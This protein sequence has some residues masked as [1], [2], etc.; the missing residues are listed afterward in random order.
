MLKRKSKKPTSDDL[1]SE[2]SLSREAALRDPLGLHHQWYLDLRLREEIARTEITKSDGALVAWQLS[3]LPGEAIDNDQF[4]RSAK[5]IAKAMRSYDIIARTDERRF[6]AIIF[7]ANYE[8][9]SAVAHRVCLELQLV[10]SQA[11]RWKA[12]VA[13]FRRDGRNGE[14]LIERVLSRIDKA[15]KATAA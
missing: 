1:P 13:S 4:A 10:V 7:D 5:I 12:G 2:Q 9:A 15:S 3:V 8:S 11:G 14:E 6:F